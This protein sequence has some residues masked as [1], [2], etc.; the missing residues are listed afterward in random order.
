MDRE[1]HLNT[2]SR[3]EPLSHEVARQLLDYIFAQGPVPGTRLPSERELARRLGVGRSAVREALKSLGFLGLLEV[4]QGD[5]TY[6]R[7]A[8]SELLPR[9][10]EWGLFLGEQRILDLLE[11]R[12]LLEENA[13]VLAAQRRTD[14]DIK[15]IQRTLRSMRDSS[16]RPDDF[17]AADIDFHLA[18]AE[19]THNTTLRDLMASMRALLSVWMSRVV[20]ASDDQEASYL[21]HLP[22]AEA[23]LAGDSRKARSAMKR[24]MDSASRRL[25]A[26]LAADV[27]RSLRTGAGP[28]ARD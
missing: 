10:I 5:G 2:M 13:A 19:A 27:D 7:P 18:I 1:P 26:T 4:R 9:L 23:V 28:T 3:R 24:H 8:G 16:R 15:S 20:S 17:V 21:E 11:V 22:V 14:D 25:T 6:I 12:Q